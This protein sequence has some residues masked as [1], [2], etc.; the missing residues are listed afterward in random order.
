MLTQCDTPPEGND[1][2]LTRRSVLRI[3]AFGGLIVLSDVLRLRAQN[4]AAGANRAPRNKSV[5]LAYLEGGASHLDTYDLKPDAPREFRGVFDPVDTNVPGIQI[6]EELEKQS[7]I[8][9]KLAIL[10]GVVGMVDGHNDAAVMSGWNLDQKSA[11]GQP[12]LG[13]VVSRFHGFR[14]P[15]DPRSSPSAR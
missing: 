14:R 10:R 13:S 5:T 8:M 7:Q 2:N 6:C 12:S 11:S 3:G 4:S 1:T 15:G 9:D